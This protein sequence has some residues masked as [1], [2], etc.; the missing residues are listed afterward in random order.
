MC[1]TDYDV[2]DVY[3]GSYRKAN[4]EHKCEECRRVIN[5]GEKYFYVSGI[6]DGSP[7]SFKTCAHC[8]QAIKLLSRECNGYMHGSIYEDIYDHISE[9]LPWSGIA[10]RLAIGMRRKWRRFDGQGLMKPVQI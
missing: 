3:C 10:A 4:K 6:W 5:K 1:M 9:I 7:G 2:P 8:D